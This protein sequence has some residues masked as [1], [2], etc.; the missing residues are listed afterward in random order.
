MAIERIKVQWESE[1]SEQVTTRTEAHSARTQFL[2]RAKGHRKLVSVTRC[3]RAQRL[4][5][6]GLLAGPLQARGPLVKVDAVVGLAE[7]LVEKDDGGLEGA[8]GV[9]ESP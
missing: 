1:R 3:A 4:S 8:A 9:Q 2:S 7:P 6:A 5:C